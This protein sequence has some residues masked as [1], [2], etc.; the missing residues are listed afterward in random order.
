MSKLAIL[1][2]T[3]FGVRSDNPAFHEYY[4]K[5]YTE[6]FFPYLKENNIHIVIQTGDMFDRRKYINFQTLALCRKYFFDNLIKNDITMISYLGNHDIFYRNTLTVN[7]PEL[8][9]NDYIN[10]SDESV[11]IISKPTTRGFGASFFNG[12]DIDIVPW[13]CEEN[14]KDSAHFM[15]NSLNKICFGHFDILGFKMNK[16]QVCLEGFD[17]SYFKNY[18]MVIS[19]HFHHKSSKGNIHYVGAPCEHTWS[20]YGSDKGFH[21]MNTNTRELTFIENPHHIF[22]KIHYDETLIDK[23]FWNIPLYK[24]TYIKV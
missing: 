12:H 15:E 10:G 19:G 8:L 24:D 14:A 17:P 23:T 18:E 22:Y 6:V 1:G 3:H 13:I 4:R 20:D 5:F 21:I 16:D 9:L 7:S 11:Q 2:D